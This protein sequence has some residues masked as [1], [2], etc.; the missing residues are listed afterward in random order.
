LTILNI[1][2]TTC[3]ILAS[4][5]GADVNARL[6]VETWTPQIVCSF[7]RYVPFNPQG[8]DVQLIALNVLLLMQPST[9]AGGKVGG[10][11]PRLKAAVVSHA[12][13]NSAVEPPI[14]AP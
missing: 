2:S 11:A 7:A 1:E 13:I 14:K 6:S 12:L 5:Y 10:R 4:M 3:V 8:S 9:D